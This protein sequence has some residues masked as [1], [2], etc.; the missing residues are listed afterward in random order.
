M[1]DRGSCD[2]PRAYFGNVFLPQ[3]KREEV[4]VEREFSLTLS[5]HLPG[6][7]PSKKKYYNH[8]QCLLVI[9]NIIP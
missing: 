9:N 1:K 8:K 4:F 7:W 3:S 2:I 5:V 6:T